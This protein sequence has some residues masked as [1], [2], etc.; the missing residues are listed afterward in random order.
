MS[1]RRHTY[2]RLVNP[3]T[4]AAALF[5]A[6]AVSG[7]RGNW[8]ALAGQQ[9]MSCH[10][11]KYMKKFWRK[12]NGWTAGNCRWCSRLA[13]VVRVVCCR[14]VLQQEGKA[15]YYRCQAQPSAASISSLRKPRTFGLFWCVYV[16]SL[17]QYFRVFVH[18]DVRRCVG[19]CAIFCP[20]E[21]Q[22]TLPPS[23]ELL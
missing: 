17:C 18:A 6:T 3:S 11:T 16:R 2:C 15:I 19:Q 13:E 22:D 20:R 14:T 9:P 1:K 8:T 4:S 12:I 5:R 23:E 10:I 21:R 7:L